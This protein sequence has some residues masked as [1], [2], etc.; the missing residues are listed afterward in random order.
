[1]SVRREQFGPMEKTKL[2]VTRL[3]PQAGEGSVHAYFGQYGEVEDVYMPKAG[4][5]SK[6]IAFVTFADDSIVQKVLQAG[7]TQEIAHG[8]FVALDVARPK[9]AAKDELKPLKIFLS[10]IPA[11]VGID[12]LRA[13]LAQHG[14]IHDVY[15]PK[16]Q[17]GALK[18][19]AF[20]TFQDAKVVSQVLSQG[21]QM[22][23]TTPAGEPVTIHVEAA[24]P[25]D[26]PPVSGP[27]NT[28][29]IGPMHNG[30]ALMPFPSGYPVGF[31][32]VPAWD[33]RTGAATGAH[34]YAPPI[35]VHRLFITKIRPHLT[36]EQVMQY[37][38]N[39]GEM[40]DFFMPKAG[41]KKHKGIAF[42]TYMN[43]NVAQGVLSRRNVLG[44]SELV[45]E[46][47][48]ERGPAPSGGG[49]LP[50]PVTAT[51][52][53][54]GKYKLFIS[55]VS[56]DVTPQ[57]LADGFSRFG[58]VEDVYIPK[59]AQTGRSKGVAY[60]TFGDR[61][62]TLKALKAPSMTFSGRNAK[63]AMS[64]VPRRSK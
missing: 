16:G 3:P 27:L 24:R 64:T 8:V 30:Q 11:D 20:V 17:G 5:R 49:P 22:E 34:F 26:A 40:S 62:S 51:P 56:Y 60:V 19:T 36:Q 28:M 14:E 45:I 29:Q 52:D 2:F 31:G 1:L 50:D 39:F 59:H 38:S 18:G 46:A 53:E 47:A 32:A 42:V 55:N 43:P 41:E 58:L 21:P 13:Q 25:K 57:M 10:G 6:G 12:K 23:I 4:N 54:S 63:V 15:M 48:I 44:D 7:T 37:F 33:P 61:V 35:P 9:D